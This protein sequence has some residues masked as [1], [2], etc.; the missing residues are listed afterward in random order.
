MYVN[1]CPFYYD[2]ADSCAIINSFKSII[3]KRSV[4]LL[5][6][7]SLA[8]LRPLALLIRLCVYE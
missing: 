2:N 3:R 4:C 5:A 1:I 8:S 6:W 7:V